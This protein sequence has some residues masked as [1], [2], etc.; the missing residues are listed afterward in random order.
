MYRNVS[1]RSKLNLYRA[2]INEDADDDVLQYSNV[3]L[4]DSDLEGEYENQQAMPKIQMYG[5]SSRVMPASG[6]Q[7]AEAIVVSTAGDRSSSFIIATDDRRYRKNNQNPG[8]VSMYDHQ[9]Q[10][11]QLQQNGV[12]EIN[13]V[14]TIVFKIGGTVIATL[15]ANG[16]VVNGEVTAN[17]VHLSTHNHPETSDPIPGT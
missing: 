16:L 6:K 17:G 15:D 12:V 13:A 10:Y 1:D 7:A 5:F 11:V 14:E 4:G 3:D 2:V 9:G 8:E